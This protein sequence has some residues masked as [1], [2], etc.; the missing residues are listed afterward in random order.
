MAV[1][2]KELALHLRGGVYRVY[3]TTRAVLDLLAEAVALFGPHSNAAHLHEPGSR[4]RM[5]CGACAWLRRVAEATEGG[6]GHE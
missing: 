6:E 3:P 4:E 1:E 5:T 2:A